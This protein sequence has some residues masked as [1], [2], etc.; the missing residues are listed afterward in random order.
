VRWCGPIDGRIY[1]YICGYVNILTAIL[2]TA[3]V[4]L[5]TKSPSLPPLT[6]HPVNVRFF[7]VV[8]IVSHHDCSVPVQYALQMSSYIVDH[9]QF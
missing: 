4:Y 5:V 6:S 7:S 9:S 8:S 1:L 3:C 2:C